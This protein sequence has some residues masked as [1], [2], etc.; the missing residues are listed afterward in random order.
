MGDDDP[1]G[2][3]SNVLHHRRTLLENAVEDAFTESDTAL[4]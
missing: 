2:L 4:G 1:N 3:L